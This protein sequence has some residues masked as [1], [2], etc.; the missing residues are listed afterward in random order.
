MES[1]LKLLWMGIWHK[2]NY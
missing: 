2:R 1:D